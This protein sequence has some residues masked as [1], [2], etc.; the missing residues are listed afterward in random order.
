M[1]LDE[2]EEKVNVGIKTSEFLLPAIVLVG[3]FTLIGIGKLPA[4]ITSLGALVTLA[5][6]YGVQRT[7][8]K[9]K[10]NGNGGA[11]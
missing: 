4:D 11:K 9:A 1:L 7:I 5:L 8:L 6:G 3:I 2:K 10:T